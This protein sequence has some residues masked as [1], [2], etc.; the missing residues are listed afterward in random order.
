VLKRI[1]SY[2]TPYTLKWRCHN[3]PAAESFY[4]IRVPP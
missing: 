3:L 1:F 4:G 2:N